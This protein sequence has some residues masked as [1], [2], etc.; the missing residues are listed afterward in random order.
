MAMF[1]LDA[2]LVNAV[3]QSVLSSN[4]IAPKHPKLWSGMW[5]RMKD[6]PICY[7]SRLISIA[8]GTSVKLYSPKSVF[9]FKAFL[10]L[11]FSRIMHAQMIAKT[12]RDFCIDQH[13]K[14]LN[15]P[16]YTSD[17]SPIERVWD[18]LV[19]VSLEFR[20][21]QL[22]KNFGCAYKRYGILL[23]NKTFKI[24]LIPFHVV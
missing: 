23:Y 15:W 8:V 20:N 9:Y 18:W 1:E 14:L 19:V 6:D 24:C 3:F 10:E 17:M 22:Q 7:E 13:M 21:L 5:F 16:A 2:M 12:I 11:S 4:D